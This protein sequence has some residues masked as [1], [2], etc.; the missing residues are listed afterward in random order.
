MTNGIVERLVLATGGLEPTATDLADALWLLRAVSPAPVVPPAPRPAT[1]EPPE[2]PE[3]QVPSPPAQPGPGEPPETGAGPDPAHLGPGTGQAAEPALAEPVPVQV[4]VHHEAA[5][6]PVEQRNTLR[7]P[8]GSAL[9]NRLGLELALRPLKRRVRN[10]AGTVLDADATA[11]LA[12]DTDLWL[13]VF[14]PAEERWLD[15]ALV[16]DE[17]RSME[18]SAQTV[19]ELDTLLRD[20]GA[21]RDVR[22]WS[23]DS[24]APGVLSVT[25]RGSGQR[26]GPPGALVDPRRRRA[27]VVVSDTIGPAWRDGRM[28]AALSV[29]ADAGPVAVVQPLPQRLWDDCGPR[30]WPVRLRSAGPGAANRDLTYASASPAIVPAESG[31]AIPVLELERRWLASWA[32]LMTAGEGTMFRGKALLLGRMLDGEHNAEGPAGP[33]ETV[34]H[35]FAE[36]ASKDAFRLAELLAAA[37]PLTLPIMTL[38]QNAQLPESAPSALREVFLGGLLIRV[39]SDDSPHHSRTAEYDFLPGL[40]SVLLGELSRREALEVLAEV[41]QYLARRLGVSV[42]FLSVLAS[43]EDVVDLDPAYKAFA[44]VAI[45]VLDAAGGVYRDRAE[46]LR[47]LMGTPVR[48]PSSQRSRPS[49]ENVVDSRGVTLSQNQAAIPAMLPT[50]AGWTSVPSRNTNFVGREDILDNVRGLLLNSPQTA[51]LLPRALFGLGGV[52]KTQI[53]LEYAHRHRARGDYDLIWW[54]AAEDP[55]EVRRSL[56]DLAKELKLPVTGDS[57]ETIRRVLQALSD[58]SPYR[59]WLI[60]FDNAPDP[61]SLGAGLTAESGGLVPD[62]RAG[63]VLITTRELSWT[64]GGRSVQV[65]VGLF[66]REESVALLRQGIRPGVTPPPGIR[67]EPIMS[68][69]DAQLVAQRLGDFPISLAQAAA[70]IRETGRS[71]QE[72]L[73]LVDEEMT[74]QQ[75]A[76]L[77]EGYPRHASAAMSIAIRQLDDSSATAAQLLR[78]SSYFGPEWIS[79]DMLYRARLAAQS[80]GSVESVLRDQ[81]PLQRTVRTIGRLELARYDTRRERFQIHRL[82]Q[83]MVQAEMDSSQQVEAAR[84]VQQMLAQANPGNPDRIAQSEMDK[85]AELSAHIVPSGVIDSDQAAARRVVL[86]QIR[87]RFNLGDY[88]SSRDLAQLVLPAWTARWGEDDELTLLARRHLANAIRQL[89]DT[90]RALE[91]DEEILEAFRRTLGPQHEHS[92]ATVNSVTAGLRALGRFEE[93]LRLD[94]ENYE[95]Q[96]RTLGEEDVSTLRTANSVGVDYRMVGNFEAALEIDQWNVT[97]GRALLGSRHGLYFAWVG[98]VARDLYGLGNYSESL[99]VQEEIFPRM[100]AVL[101]TNH[102]WTLGARRIIVMG[103]R[104]LGQAAKAETYAR[105]LLIASQ[106]RLGA[107]HPE[108][109]LARVSL[110]NV[111]RETGKLAEAVEAGRT[112]MELYQGRVAEQHYRQLFAANMAIVHRQASEVQRARELNEVTLGELRASFGEQ[113]PYTLCCASNLASDLAATGA[114]GEALTLSRETYETSVTVR[115]DAHPYTLAAANNYAIDLAANG[116]DAATLRQQTLDALRRA[117]GEAHPQTVLAKDG[118][119]IDADIEPSPA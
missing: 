79:L 23:C 89:G 14:A 97:A 111:L 116:E 112:T 117:L 2:A 32:A 40:R 48:V 31:V 88:E 92:M 102:T 9:P 17:S 93:A 95:L 118:K 6:P 37:A 70:W 52:G 21:F 100:E 56:V 72:Y 10:G 43:E 101:G 110:V 50:P 87:Y 33:P 83:A 39:N 1:P 57:A 69:E 119:R 35:R 41:S 7:T 74:R 11:D 58:R 68:E 49:R 28:A 80:Y 109:L 18:V 45:A 104:K 75:E 76:H 77:P 36:T 53:A 42:D 63:H 47:E 24:D 115:G 44:T 61:Q 73:R 51:V 85:H 3:S 8:A 34:L 64:E 67:N 29:W 16:V 90:V 98:N 38:I 60:V 19:G 55:S 65:E 103:Y 78:L 22:L 15:V 25:P 99:R 13:P 108:T 46:R 20:L 84:T 4:E 81:A 54:V 5:V 114:S 94:R 62:T 71:I 107:A 106:N 27:V 82:V 30:V 66:S 105:E 86:D 113:H 59:R 91:L 12:A 26:A 96:L